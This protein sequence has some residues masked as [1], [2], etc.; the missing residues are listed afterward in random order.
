VLSFRLHDQWCQLLP[1]GKRCQSRVEC[2]TDILDR[3]ATP[4]T[5]R[6]AVFQSK[7]HQRHVRPMLQSAIIF[8]HPLNALMTSPPNPVVVRRRIAT[9]LRHFASAA[10]QSVAGKEMRC[11]FVVSSLHVPALSARRY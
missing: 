6:D 10:D 1:V 7:R 8:G 11:L 3:W 4:G 2:S 5:V 9:K